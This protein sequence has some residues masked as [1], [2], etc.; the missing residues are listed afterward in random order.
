MADQVSD[1]KL[2]HLVELS[3]LGDGC[4]EL[5][6]QIEDWL[7]ANDVVFDGHTIPF[8]LMPHFVSP[9]QVRRVRR[10]VECLSA[11]LNRFC[12]AY[13]DD[14]RLQEELALPS[15]RGLA[16]PRQSRLPLP[17]PHLPPRRLPRRR[18]GQVPRVQRRLAGRHRLH[19]RPS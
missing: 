18:P 19:R 2:Q 4:V 6:S 13:P 1:L 14:A 15:L 5:E 17:A 8:V 11:V 9:G 12:D 16:G 3:K 10:A 7:V